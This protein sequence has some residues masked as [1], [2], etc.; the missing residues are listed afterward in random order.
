MEKINVVLVALN[1][2][3]LGQAMRTL[4][5]EKANLVAVVVENINSRFLKIN[6]KKVP[7]VPFPAIQR[8]LDAG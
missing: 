7:I 1:N 5:L 4:N 6:D 3:N 8:L 2:K